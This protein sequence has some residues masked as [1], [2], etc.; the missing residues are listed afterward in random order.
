[1]ETRPTDNVRA[2]VFQGVVFDFYG[3]LSVAATAVA[4]R[5]GVT[6]IADALEIP[7]E[8]LQQ[9]IATS[10]TERA[11]GAC[12]NLEETMAW[13]A[14]RC[15]Q[16]PSSDQLARAC[17]IRRETEEV[18]ARALRPEAEPTLRALGDRHIKVGLLSDC[19]HE[20]PEIWPTLPIA[21]LVDA[22]VF[23]VVA[24]LRKPAPELYANVTSALALSPA[25][26]LY[27]GDGGSGELTGATSVGMTALQLVA[28]DAEQAIVYDADTAWSGKTVSSLSDVLDHV[29][30]QP[31]P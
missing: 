19:T 30:H 23:S 4:R 22:A 11:T 24:R 29:G 31:R 16:S 15:G 17:A 20:L 1:M 18:Y 28:P 14:D 25:D 26:C 27:V 8:V 3:T 5:A 12:G 9:A 10:F 6:R 2:V 13:L 21:P 7:A